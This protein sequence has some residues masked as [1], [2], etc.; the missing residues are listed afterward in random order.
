MLFRSHVFSR[1][2]ANYHGVMRCCTVRSSTRVDIEGETRL[3]EKVTTAGEPIG[4]KD[5]KTVGNWTRFWKHC[6]GL[7]YDF[8][9]VIRGAVLGLVGTECMNLFHYVGPSKPP[10]HVG[11]EEASRNPARKSSIS[12]KQRGNGGYEPGP[13]SAWIPGTPGSALCCPPL[14]LICDY[15]WMVWGHGEI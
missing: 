13:Q 6:L 3:T 15:R 2:R 10:G 14:S 11:C 4:P 1:F 8:A 9:K 12:Q 5:F 7:F